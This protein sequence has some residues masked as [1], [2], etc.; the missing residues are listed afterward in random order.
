ML[1]DMF[2]RSRAYRLVGHVGLNCCF[3]NTAN[4]PQVVSNFSYF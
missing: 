3:L 2:N 1:T 4:G